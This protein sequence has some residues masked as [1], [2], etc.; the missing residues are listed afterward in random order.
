[1]QQPLLSCTSNGSSYAQESVMKEDPERSNM[2]GW[3]ANI[4]NDPSLWNDHQEIADI[5][6]NKVSMNDLE[7]S[8]EER[9]EKLKKEI[10][11]LSGSIRDQELKAKAISQSPGSVP[12]GN[13]KAFNTSDGLIIASLTTSGSV[14]SPRLFKNSLDTSS[15]T[16]TVDD[17][18]DSPFVKDSSLSPQKKGSQSSEVDKSYQYYLFT[19]NQ[20]S[21]A[22][23][24][25]EE[26]R[27]VLEEEGYFTQAEQ[28]HEKIKEIYKKEASKIEMSFV[29]VVN[30]LKLELVSIMSKEMD[31][32]EQV[33]KQKTSQFEAQAKDLLGN[34]AQRQN[35][36][37]KQTEQVM[38]QQMHI[39]KPKFSKTV[40]EQRARVLTLVRTKNYKQAETL[41]NQL[42]PLELK[43]IEKFERHQEE[44]LKKKLSYVESRH[45]M[46][47]D[48]LHQRIMSGRRELEN[49]KR[50]ELTAVTQQQTVIIQEFENKHRKALSQIKQFI[51]KLEG[52]VSTK[53]RTVC[54]FFD[55]LPREI[56]T[57]K[58]TYSNLLEQLK[59]DF[60]RNY[61]LEGSSQPQQEQPN[62]SSVES[63]WLIVENNFDQ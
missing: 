41:K 43:E 30:A 61:P 46:E 39:H 40:L 47:M 11:L 31:A 58:T 22:V 7:M 49:I 48:V 52:I 9:I 60:K 53:R 45:K 19:K 42:I 18:A 4:E 23:E 63:K 10:A 5:I 38:R 12:Y 59:E 37:L 32:F 26:Q 14:S 21:L 20:L 57:F 56:E 27:L 15:S 1:M 55:T 16:L 50:K 8:E 34:T 24:E 29:N 28:V 2:Q 51:S 17:L 36:E 13:N 54:N 25:L 6:S 3:M 44:K 62:R 33:W 35:A